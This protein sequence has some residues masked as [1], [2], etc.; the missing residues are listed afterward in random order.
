MRAVHVGAGNIGRGFIGL[1]L[2]RA[3][4]QVTFADVV[5]SL[6][7]GLKQTPSYRVFV[8]DEQV[9][10]EDVRGFNAVLLDS[11]ECRLAMSEAD[12]ITTAVGVGNLKSVASIIA[13]ALRLRKK[14][15]NSAPLHVMACENA[16]RATSMLETEILAHL[17]ADERVYVGA[18]VG[19]ADVAVD[20][21]APNRQGYDLEPYDAVVERFFEWDIE[22]R[23]LKTKLPISGATFVDVLDP[24]LE[25]KLFILN[26]A[27]ATAAYAGYLRGYET[28][29]EA[30]QDAHVANLVQRVQMEAAAGLAHRYAAFSLRDL[31]VYANDVQ[32][33]F[34][35]PHVRDEVQRVGRDPRRKL[36]PDD[37]LVRPLLFAR[38]AGIETSG[39]I[40]AIA[41]GLNYRNPLDE[42]SVYVEQRIAT[43]GVHGAIKDVTCIEDDALIEQIAD[44][45]DQVS[46][47]K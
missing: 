13:D 6:V 8:L 42:G 1:L 38:E 14:S 2:S 31:Q 25:R 29:L 15:G 28:I 11:A 21:I 26:G 18:S 17:N 10:T 34:R 33:R 30:M 47:A 27:H 37:R 40:E 44:V 39:L 19:F 16:I 4:Y 5:P 9:E 7:E 20:R 22:T 35:N 3:G 24:Y 32:A 46:Q 43:S 12:L 23:N 41:C 36:G 45:Y